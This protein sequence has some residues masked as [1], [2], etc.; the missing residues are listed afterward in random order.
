MNKNVE[1]NLN[2]EDQNKKLY[3]GLED[4]F[5]NNWYPGKTYA[6][7]HFKLISNVLTQLYQNQLDDK[8]IKAQ[9]WINT[10]ANPNRLDFELVHGQEKNKIQ[11]GKIVKILREHFLYRNELYY[12]EGSSGNTKIVQIHLPTDLNHR[13]KIIRKCI[14]YF[15]QIIQTIDSESLKQNN[16]STRKDIFHSALAEDGYFRESSSKLQT[17]IPKH[18]RL[19][20]KFHEW[21]MNKGINSS[22]EKNY[23]DILFKHNAKN[24]IAELKVVYEVG[25]TKSIR[26]A[27]GQLLEYNF[28]KGRYE[29][30]EWMIILNEKPLK[31][32]LIYIQNLIDK[33]NFPIRLGWQ[34]KNSFKFHPPWEI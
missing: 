25:T 20:N 18:N 2:F 23:I 6:K 1:N 26:E 28:Y 17:I 27:L 13:V 24:Y 9:F 21:L 31:S 19:S 12:L 15:N 10:S 5:D 32:D 11:R 30:D 3:Q 14:K 22:Q 33:Y 7:K 4:L 34:T 16:Y 29:N 8:E